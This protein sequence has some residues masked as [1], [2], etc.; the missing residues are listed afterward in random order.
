MAPDTGIEPVLMDLESTVLTAERIWHFY[1]FLFQ[2]KIIFVSEG[3][4]TSFLQ[5]LQQ[6][7]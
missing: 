6:T 5:W 1:Y 3:L 2:L 7:L 4:F